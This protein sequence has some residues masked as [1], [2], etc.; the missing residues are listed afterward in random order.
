MEAKFNVG[1]PSGRKLDWEVVAKEMRR[2]RNEDCKRLFG[3]SEFLSRLAAKLRQKQLEVTDHD[4]RAAEDQANFSALRA[5]VPSS[6]QIRHPIAVDQYNVCDIQARRR[7]GG[8]FEG[9]EPSD[10]KRR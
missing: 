8:G 6:I 2:A 1:Q 10:P 3:V 4:V 7:G 5:S 9:F